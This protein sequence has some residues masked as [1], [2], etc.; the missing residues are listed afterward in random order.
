MIARCSSWAAPNGEQSRWAY[1]KS[2]QEMLKRGYLRCGGPGRDIVAEIQQEGQHRMMELR[3]HRSRY[4]FEFYYEIV[5]LSGH[6]EI[7]T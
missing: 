3:G 7:G 2:P 1:L 6:H 4:G 5:D